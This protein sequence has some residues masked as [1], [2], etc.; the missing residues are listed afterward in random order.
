MAPTALST[1]LMY[2]YDGAT[3]TP[4]MLR[5][6]QGQSFW[7]TQR[8]ICPC[9]HHLLECYAP[10]T[11]PTICTQGMATGSPDANPLCN[12]PWRN[13]YVTIQLCTCSEKELERVFNCSVQSPLSHICHHRTTPS[14][15]QIKLFGLLTTQTCT[16]SPSTRPSKAILQRSPSTGQSSSSTQG[17]ASFSL[18]SSI[19]RHGLDRNVSVSW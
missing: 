12:R 16:V 14:Y 4:M 17:L 11:L 8:T 9:I 1:G 18:K 19:H 7:T 5:D 15:S 2:S 10:S 13:L 3:M 6:T